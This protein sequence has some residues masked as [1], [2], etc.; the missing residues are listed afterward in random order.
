MRERTEVRAFLRRLRTLAAAIALLVVLGTLG[1]ALTEHVS[2]WEG[3]QWSLDTIATIGS[4]PP[5]ETLAG[6]IIK[7]LL[8][9]LGVGTLFYG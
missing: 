9:V 8:I 4:H 1:L 2:G 7:V 3:F 5:P 6:Q